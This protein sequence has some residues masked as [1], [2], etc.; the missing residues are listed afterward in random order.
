[1]EIRYAELR[2]AAAIAE[3]EA[4]CFPAAEA[5]S[6]ESIKNRLLHYPN[7]FWL[8]EDNGRLV[9]FANGMV[10]NEEHLLDE[11]F[12]H[13]EMHDESGKWQLIFGLDTIPEY[14]RRGCGEQLLNR[15]IEDAR[16]Q[17]RTG[18]ILTCKERLIHYYEKFG[19]VQEGLSGSTHGGVAW[20]D[21]RLT[22]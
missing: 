14:R 2:D 6:M 20:Y 1:M 16:K 17:G 18:L 4:A 13:A 22:F 19:F 9:G 11:M 3:V 7:H 8:L 5:A 15:V 12:D 21:M 10:S